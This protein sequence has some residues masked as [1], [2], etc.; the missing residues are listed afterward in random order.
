VDER[1]VLVLPPNR[2]DGDVTR[3]LLAQAR[4]SCIICHDAPALAREIEAGAG[5]I[6]LTDVALL[7]ADFDQ[8]QAA[9]SR[10]APWSDLPVVLLCPTGHQS[11]L[12]ERV[13]ASFTNVTLLDRP[14]SARTLVSAVHAAIRAR[15]RQYQTREQ[16]Q[17][18]SEAQHSLSERER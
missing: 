5:A 3:E 10:Q 18:L 13:I 12:A 16:L 4:L 6:V 1:S 11:P 9:L 15:C 2:R 8:V 14:T 17:A 7:T